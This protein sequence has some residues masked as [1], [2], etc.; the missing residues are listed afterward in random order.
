VCL[1][2]KVFQ[3]CLGHIFAKY[4]IPYNPIQIP[5]SIL[6]SPLPGASWSEASI[7]KWAIDTNGEPLSPE[8]KEEIMENLEVTTDGRLLQVF[9][10]LTR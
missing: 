1:T 3:A 6:L 9:P 5:N 2:L 4:C 8:S 10:T 7:D